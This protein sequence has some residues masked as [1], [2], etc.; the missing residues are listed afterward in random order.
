MGLFERKE[1]VFLEYQFLCRTCDIFF[2]RNNPNKNR[3]PICKRESEIYNVREVGNN[4]Q[5]RNDYS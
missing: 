3:C 5:R 4:E 2:Y 1:Q